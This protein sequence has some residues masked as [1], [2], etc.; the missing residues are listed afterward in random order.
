MKVHRILVFLILIAFLGTVGCGSEEKVASPKSNL[1][2]KQLKEATPG[3]KEKKTI[4]G[5]EPD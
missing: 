1:K 2:D 3:G 5:T 4:P